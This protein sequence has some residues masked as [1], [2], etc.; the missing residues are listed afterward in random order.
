[1]STPGCHFSHRSSLG[2][3]VFCS[4]CTPSALGTAEGYTHLCGGGLLELL[5]WAEGARDGGGDAGDEVMQ[6]L[7][8]PTAVARFHYPRPLVEVWRHCMRS[9][10]PGGMM[11]GGM[12]ACATVRVSSR[13]C[14][15]SMHACVRE[16]LSV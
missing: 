3:C 1:M 8:I 10:D 15:S 9:S 12:H 14:T 6:A 2:L 16:T 7:G 13:P 4:S 11:A 5:R